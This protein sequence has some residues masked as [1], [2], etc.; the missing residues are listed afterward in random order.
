MLAPAGLAQRNSPVDSTGRTRPTTSWPSP[1]AA[2]PCR[3]RLCRLPEA[4]RETTAVPRVRSSSSC[5]A[6][7]RA[8]RRGSAMRLRGPRGSPK[9]RGPDQARQSAIG[10]EK[11]HPTRSALSATRDAACTP[12]SPRK[13]SVGAPPKQPTSTLPDRRLAHTP[14]ATQWQPPRCCTG[15][16]R[17]GRTTLLA[18]DPRCRPG[19]KWSNPQTSY[20][21]CQARAQRRL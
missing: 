12:I 3:R 16:P 14:R 8:H 19:P 1:H 6:P 7:G 17:G 21:K 15:L 10:T 11:V 13:R 20:E 5:C 9:P 4:T 18:P 2:P